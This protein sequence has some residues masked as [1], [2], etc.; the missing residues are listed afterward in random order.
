MSHVFEMWKVMRWVGGL[1]IIVALVDC[2]Q[3]SS[4]QTPTISR[5]TVVLEEAPR[6][7]KVV[8]ALYDKGKFSEAFPLAERSL[9]LREQAWNLA[10]PM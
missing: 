9:A 6:L 5:P 4:T 1:A 3:L 7:D 10:T 2:A 8:G